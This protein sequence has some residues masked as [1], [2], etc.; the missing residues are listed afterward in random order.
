M[1]GKVLVTPFEASVRS[2]EC[3]AVLGHNGAGK[4]TLFHLILGLKFPEGG[5]ILIGGLSALEFRARSGL[6][7][8]PERPYVNLDWGFREFLELHAGL[9]GLHRDQISAE[10]D[11]VSRNYGLHANLNQRLRSFSKGMLQKAIFAQLSIG[12]PSVIILDEPMSG[13]DPEARELVRSHMSE[14]KQQKKTILFSSH[15]L[16]DVELLADRVMVLK[17]GNLQFVGS[18]SEW[19]THS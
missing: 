17:E 18:L 9:A 11:R 4:T 6:G 10:V 14:W 1:K 19:R 13:L 3:M 5:E 12:D 8:L 2:G 16:E 15:S 7:Y